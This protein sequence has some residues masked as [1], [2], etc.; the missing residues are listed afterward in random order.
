MP[1]ID[2]IVATYPELPTI[3]SYIGLASAVM[4]MIF[5]LISLVAA[6]RAHHHLPGAESKATSM[7]TVTGV[8]FTITLIILVILY[9]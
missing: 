9:L 6:N 4:T 8:C 7:F 2:P 3:L 5:L 1:N